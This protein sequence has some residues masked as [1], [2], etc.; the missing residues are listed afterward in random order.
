VR[1]QILSPY[2]LCLC[3]FLFCLPGFA[4]PH[5]GVEYVK[6]E[7][8]G[9]PVHLV[10]VDLARA[11]L[12]IRPVVAPA[13]QRYSMGQFVKAHR[14]L[15]A[16]NGTFF[17]TLTGV[18]V[19]N[20]V[21]KGRLL[22]EGMAG[23]N[24]VFR[25]DGRVDL[26]SSGRNLGRYQDWADVDF[27]IGGGP[28]LLAHGDY[29]VDPGREGFRDPSLFRPRPRTAMGVTGDGKLRM[30]VVTQAVSLWTLAHIMKDLGCIHALNLDGGS[31][32][33]MSVG[34]T[35]MVSP[36]R[37]LTNMVGVFSVHKD[38]DLGRAVGVAEIRASQHYLRGQ[39]YAALGMR[40]EARSQMRQAVAKAPSEPLYWKAAGEAEQS[41]NNLGR[42]VADLA[43]AA[44]LYMGQG[45]LV[46]A[47]AVAR[48]IL[49]LDQHNQHA[50]LVC[51]E[52]LIEQGFDQEARPHLLA[53]LASSPGHQ[54]ATELLEG[55]EFRAR[56]QEALRVHEETLALA[57]RVSALG[58]FPAAS[59]PS[60][61]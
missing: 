59:G 36:Q 61:P 48:W 30:V 52:A 19:G 3:L 21:S 44:E 29:V 55:V 37:R 11:D 58:A 16:I 56:R 22:T 20:L 41:M 51:G 17:D 12:V 8:A 24:L 50:N 33:A 45:D 39:E 9:V 5:D 54:R 4:R 32:S 7:A 40:P 60:G 46:A 26:I 43:R 34:G 6:L 15:A 18:T 1:S 31:S 35:A 38:A 57:W 23:S 14:P 2:G 49:D 42:A 27:A 53:V 25:G 47:E 10:N 13:G 28:T